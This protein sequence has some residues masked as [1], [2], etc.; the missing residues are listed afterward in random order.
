[1]W[2]GLS[3]PE[4]YA[5]DPEN[6]LSQNPNLPVFI[7]FQGGADNVVK[8]TADNVYYSTTPSPYASES[9]CVLGG[10]YTLPDNGAKNADLR[11]FGSQG[12]CD[13]L[14]NTFRIRNELYI[15]C[16][17]QHGLNES[18]SDFGLANGN[19]A[20]VTNKQVQKYIVQRAATFF[21]YVMN[22]NFP[23]TLSHTRFVDC[24]NTRYGCDPD[25]GTTCDNNLIC[26]NSPGAS[27]GESIARK[28]EAGQALFTMTLSNKRIYIHF[29]QAGNARV[30][31]FD[32]NG[33]P[34]RDLQCNARESFL[35]CRNLTMG[36][37]LL[38]VVQSASIQTARLILR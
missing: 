26:S 35:D 27:S 11:S 5:N 4:N 2:G 30:T 24:V 29:S 7:A 16:D 32:L 25:A 36:C 18:T 8:I 3:V 21:Q 31:L 33:L 6:F 20:A 17:M 12:I 9:L 13:I 10:T 38:R 14:T 34:L 19:A 22:P 23:Y 28:K 1:L 37:Y 15:D